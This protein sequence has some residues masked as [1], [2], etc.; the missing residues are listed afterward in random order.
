[1]KFKSGIESAV[2]TAIVFQ[3]N[4]FPEK[5]SAHPIIHGTVMPESKSTIQMEIDFQKK[6]KNIFRDNL[7]KGNFHLLVEVNTPEKKDDFSI[8]ASRLNAVYTALGK[9][10]SVSTGLAV[11]DKLHGWTTWNVADF[12]NELPG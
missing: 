5:L 8:A 2:H 11:T 7:N 3:I 12:A 6:R 4:F 1:M 10:D 9:S